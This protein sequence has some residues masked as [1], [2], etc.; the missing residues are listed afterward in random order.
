MNGFERLVAAVGASKKRIY[1]R[2]GY[3]DGHCSA[4]VMFG[5]I[6]IEV[7]GTYPDGWDRP[8][9]SYWQASLEP[10]VWPTADDLSP[11]RR[12][13]DWPQENT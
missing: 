2:P 9:Q 4:N 12:K 10:D 1:S 3:G 13:P 6:L 7:S 11:K 5:K 8:S